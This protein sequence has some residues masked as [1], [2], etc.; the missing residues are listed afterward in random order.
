[1]SENIIVLLWS[2]SKTFASPCLKI[3]SYCS[4]QEAR[5]FASQCLKTLCYCSRQ[6]ARRFPSQ[7]LKTYRIALIRKQDILLPS[8]GT[9]YPIALCRKQ[10]V[11]LPEMRAIR[12]IIYNYFLVLRFASLRAKFR[13]FASDAKCYM[14]FRDPL[15]KM[16]KY[17]VLLFRV[18][19]DQP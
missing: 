5:S 3:L 1:M 11:L 18:I 15:L 9:H 8:V 6:E 2:G 12:I 10:N 7:C 14:P 13:G 19:F 16:E 17:A 4:R